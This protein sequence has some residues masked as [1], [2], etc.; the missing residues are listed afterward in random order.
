MRRVSEVH[1][2]VDVAIAE[3]LHRVRNVGERKAVVR[4]DTISAGLQMRVA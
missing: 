3:E 2:R 1:E 4:L